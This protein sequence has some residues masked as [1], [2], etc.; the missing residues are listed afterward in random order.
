MSERRIPWH[1]V[2]V[3]AVTPFTRDARF[4]EEA[5]RWLMDQLIAD[6]VHGIIV[7]GSTGEWFA[8]SNAERIRLFEVAC[9]QVRGRVTLLAG[10]TA[11][12]TS[13]A[14]A[15]T[16]AALTLGLD[17]CLVLP[18]PYV[19]PT[20]REVLSYYEAVAAV[21]LPVMIY[22]NPPRTQV[23]IT[24]AL[25]EKL[26]SI[27]NIVALK[28]SV[29]DLMQMGET[30]RALG[31]R[32]AIFCGMEPYALPCLQRGAVGIVAMAPNIMGQRA[33]ELYTRAAAGEWIQA[34]QI[35]QE[36]DRLYAAFY[37][38]GFSAYA[39]I[40]EC[41][42][43]LGRPGGWPRPPLLPLDETA[44][45]ALQHLLVELGLLTEPG[46]ARA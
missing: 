43:L 14:V 19:L 1:G 5:C 38:P 39:V 6:G 2:F 8:L 11:M 22:N 16:E 28:D 44:R 29:K 4:D 10:T 20:E 41:M 17:G 23:N 18:P 7:A 15:L 42:N 45:S 37:A 9:D 32:L 36:I 46:L 24:A 25:A 3:P 33:V 12:A 13:D 26:A 34:H 21:G 40:K 27:E 30:I 35:E 31:N